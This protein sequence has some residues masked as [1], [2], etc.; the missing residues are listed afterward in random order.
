MRAGPLGRKELGVRT[1][2]L[3]TYFLGYVPQLV[4]IEKDRKTHTYIIW[5]H[6]QDMIYFLDISNNIFLFGMVYTDCLP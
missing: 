3:E 4:S 1:P 6:S 5:I 2:E